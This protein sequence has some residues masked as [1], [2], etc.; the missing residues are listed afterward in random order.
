VALLKLGLA[1]ASRVWR[2]RAEGLI[3]SARSGP[4]SARA[5]GREARCRCRGPRSGA[6][7]ALGHLRNG[8]ETGDR[9]IHVAEDS[10]LRRDRGTP[11]FPDV[12]LIKIQPGD[13]AMRGRFDCEA[14]PRAP[15]DQ[16]QPRPALEVGTPWS[17]IPD[18]ATALIRLAPV[19]RVDR[20]SA[21]HR[22]A[23]AAGGLHGAPLSRT[24]VSSE[25]QPRAADTSV[26]L[27]RTRQRWRRGQESGKNDQQSPPRQQRVTLSTGKGRHAAN[28]GAHRSG[29]VVGP[30]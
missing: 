30:V 26:R 12:G 7:G 10:H 16:R 15:P 5:P 27:G 20:G 19:A 23:E 21:G 3:R 9:S 14:H 6:G 25:R 2:A 13:D 17:P 29:T 18:G 28:T 8:N 4:W 1:L 24:W 22:S 11:P